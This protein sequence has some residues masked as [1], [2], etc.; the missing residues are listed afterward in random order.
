MNRRSQSLNL[1]IAEATE[2]EAEVLEPYCQ[3]QRN[4][5]EYQEVLQE[6]IA[7]ESPLSDRTRQ[8]LKALQKELNLTDESVS[9]IEQTVLDELEV[10]NGVN[11]RWLIY[12]GFDGV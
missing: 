6:E 4:L 11:S 1:K 2:I 8:E 12:D 5:Q 7:I 9:A 3:H 10:V